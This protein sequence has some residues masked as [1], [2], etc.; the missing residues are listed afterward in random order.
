MCNDGRNR[1]IS[2]RQS[3][4][5]W[6]SITQTLY[7]CVKST[8]LTQIHTHFHS[9]RELCLMAL[10]YSTHTLYVSDSAFRKHALLKGIVHPKMKIL[11]SFT[12]PQVDPNFY[13]CLSSAENRRRYFEESGFLFPVD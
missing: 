10:H 8:P 13:D 6:Y 4:G 7:L 12:H 9:P 3:S 5:V 2:L 11:L 1:F